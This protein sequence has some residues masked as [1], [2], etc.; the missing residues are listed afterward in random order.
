[1]PVLCFLDAG[2]LTRAVIV[3]ICALAASGCR[4]WS[5]PQVT[6]VTA[7]PV[8]PTIAVEPGEHGLGL[9]RVLYRRTWRDGTLFVPTRAAAG[10]VPLLVLLHG[11]AGAPPTSS[12]PSRWARSTASRS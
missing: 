10:E 4:I 5:G 2:L 8:A 9:G 7:R 11:G 12:S 6:R 3:A 1:M